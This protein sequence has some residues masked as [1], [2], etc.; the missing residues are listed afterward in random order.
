[1][2]SSTFSYDPDLAVDTDPSPTSAHYYIGTTMT[3]ELGGFLVEAPSLEADVALGT[4]EAPADAVALYDN[5][6][7]YN[8]IEFYQLNVNLVDY[9][10]GTLVDESL[11]AFFDLEQWDTRNFRLWIRQPVDV[12]SQGTLTRL[13][14]IPE[15]ATLSVLALGGFVLVSRRC[16]ASAAC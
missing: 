12:Y 2:F 15:P 11:P 3:A 7:S 16:R 14:I 10:G 4:V 13:R 9:S 5:Y 6:F 8:G 1:L